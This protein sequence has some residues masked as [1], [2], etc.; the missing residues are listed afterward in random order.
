M[1]TILGNLAKECGAE[2]IANEIRASL[3]DQCGYITYE[4]DEDLAGISKGIDE[5]Q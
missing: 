4:L 5:G 3:L 1:S 2:T